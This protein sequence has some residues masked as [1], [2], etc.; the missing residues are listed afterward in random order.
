MAAFST[1]GVTLRQIRAFIAVARIG[2][3]T[4]AAEAVGLTQPA[5]TTCIRQLEGL[6]G[7]ALFDRTTRRVELNAYGGAFL[8][9]AE[10]IVRDLDAAM[11]SMK[12]IKDGSG[13]YVSMASIGSIASSLLPAALAAFKARYPQV[14]ID[15]IEDRSE[16]VRRKVQEGEVEFGISGFTEPVLDVEIRPFFFDRVGLFCRS[17]H[18]L[19][20]LGRPLLWRDLAGMEVMNMGHEA[21]IRSV[22]EVVPEIAQAMSVASYKVRNALTTLSLIREGG[23][24]AA[25]PHLSIPPDAFVDIVFLPLS[26]PDLRRE[27]F[28]CR[29]I[30]TSLSAAAQALI[31]SIGE[32]AG[33]AGATVYPQDPAEPWAHGDAASG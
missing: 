16:G 19:A 31:A 27:I 17:D 14:G 33:K 30:R 4:H 1:N 3:F 8:P 12:S 13:G 24:I 7:V 32:S 9:T 28:L 21:M 23:F 11:A 20:T 10:R 15:I 29:H 22:A 2:S 26:E 5:L 25:L 6:V 18:P